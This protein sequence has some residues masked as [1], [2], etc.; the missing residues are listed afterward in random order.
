MQSAG[1]IAGRVT[2]VGFNVPLRNVTV[3]LFYPG[4]IL[5]G[6][7][8]TATNGTY[9]FDRLVAGSYRVCFDGQTGKGGYTLHWYSSQCWSK[10]AWNPANPMP[11]T[12]TA[13][14]VVGA[15]STG[16]I[17]AALAAS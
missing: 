15:A 10:I 2:Q 14:T 13:I 12:A 1:E 3:A 17:N 5:A 9:R 7:T 11:A 4:G 8:T 6:V 16:N